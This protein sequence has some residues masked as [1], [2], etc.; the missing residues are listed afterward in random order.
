[1][2]GISDIQQIE[3]GSKDGE[4]YVFQS[5]NIDLTNPNDVP[6]LAHY[7]TIFKQEGRAGRAQ[8]IVAQGYGSY[9]LPVLVIDSIENIRRKNRESK[10]SKEQ[11]LQEYII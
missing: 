6:R 2:E 10:I 5:R 4:V 8:S 9:H 3:L 7:K 11:L 1:M